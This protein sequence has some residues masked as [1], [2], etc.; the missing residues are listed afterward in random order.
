M[1][2]KDKQGGIIF[3]GEEFQGAGIFEGVDGVFFC[4]AYRVG[5]FQAVEVGKKVI[6]EGGRRGPAEEESSFG[7]F[8][9]KGFGLCKGAF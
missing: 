9:G 8:D 3:L 7:V 2:S 5:T 6:Y 1:A 4:E